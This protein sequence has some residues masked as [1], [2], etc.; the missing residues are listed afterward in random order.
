MT[1][2]LNGRGDESMWGMFT[3]CTVTHS[4]SQED[5]ALKKK[6]KNLYSNC[7]GLVILIPDILLIQL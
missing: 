4:H 6:E 2:N 7:S 5:G 1:L 3:H